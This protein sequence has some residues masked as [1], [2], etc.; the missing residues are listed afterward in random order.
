MTP[1]EKIE[2]DWEIESGGQVSVMTNWK[3]VE[4]DSEERRL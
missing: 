4:D 2:A 1:R 3:G